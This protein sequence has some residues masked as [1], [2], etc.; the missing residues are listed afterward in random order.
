VSAVL[1]STGH[2]RRSVLKRG[3]LVAAGALGVTAGGKEAR[4]V[5]R[6]LPDELRLFGRSWRLDAPGRVPG[7]QIR[8]GDTGVVYGELVDAPKG[9]PLGRFFGSRLAVQ[10]A[11]GGN[12]RADASVEVHTFVLPDGTLVGMG[13]AL[14]GESVF[15][16]VGGT[17]VYAGASGSYTAVQRLHE[18]GGD[19]TAEFHVTLH[20]PEA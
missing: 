6:T 11:P 7:E 18:L 4:A 19:G 17:G 5:T 2:S 14:P 3:L 12:V 20:R 8:R 16:I 9:K 10:S 1:E 13:T 15:A